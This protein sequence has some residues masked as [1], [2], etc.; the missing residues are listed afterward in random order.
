ML[1][2][3]PR[4]DVEG[5][6]KEVQLWICR[7]EGS[8]DRQGNRRRRGW[9][10]LLSV[11]LPCRDDDPSSPLS[12]CRRRPALAE[13]LTAMLHHQSATGHFDAWMCPCPQWGVP[14]ELQEPG[15]RVAQLMAHR[16]SRTDLDH[17]C[18]TRKTQ[19]Y[20]I[21]NAARGEVREV[22]FCSSFCSQR[23]ILIVLQIKL[24]IF[25]NI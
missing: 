1:A 17:I 11:F 8:R 5:H 21:T 10:I 24:K 6:E 19:T 18:L 20:R 7:A 25:T 16:S 3:S 14:V 22:S 15:D 12:C 9:R 13:R 23:I 4:A 2:K